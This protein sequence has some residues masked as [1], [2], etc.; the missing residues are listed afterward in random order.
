MI[1][2]F[3]PNEEQ[4]GDLFDAAGDPL[5][6]ARRAWAAGAGCVVVSLGPDGCLVVDADGHQHVPGRVVD[7]V[8]TTGCGDAL[9]A[10]YLRG[11]TLGYDPVRAAE[12]GVLAASLVATGLSSDAGITTLDDTLAAADRFPVRTPTGRRFG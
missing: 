12:L 8:D 10:G 7:V 3:I 11:L 5:L 2:H 1:D 9:T 6:A 4:L